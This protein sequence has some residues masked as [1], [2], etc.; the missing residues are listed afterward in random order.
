MA[1]RPLSEQLEIIEDCVWAIYEDKS[2]RELPDANGY[3]IGTYHLG[4]ALSH[5]RGA[6]IDLKASG[7]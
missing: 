3:Y 4:M 2:G 6:V 1:K 5:L 7:L